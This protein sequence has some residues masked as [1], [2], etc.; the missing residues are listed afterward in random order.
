[1]EAM[2]IRDLS[3]ENLFYVARCTHEKEDEETTWAAQVRG[4]WLTSLM[5]K[6]LRGKVAYKGDNPVG[7]IQYLPIEH[8]PIDVVGQDLTVIPC[9]VST[10]KG[11]GHGRALI[12]AAEEDARRTSRGIVIPAFDHD[13]WFMPASYFQRLGYQEADRQKTYVILWKAFAPVDPPFI[14]GR[15]Y[16]FVSEPGKVVVDLFWNRWCKTSI[17]EAQRVRGVCVEYGDHVL[18]KEYDASQRATL[19]RYGINRA[20]FFNGKSRFWGHEAPKEGIR[21]EIEKALAII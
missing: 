7:F 4:V 19:E 14:M 9:L 8:S 3:S 2:E 16:Q 1:M 21:E 17:I 12:Q 20:L 6:G 15:N 10:V 13:F 18:L 5:V 11:Q